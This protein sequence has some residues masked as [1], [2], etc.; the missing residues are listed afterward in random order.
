[1]PDWVLRDVCDCVSWLQ[2]VG[3]IPPELSIMPNIT[4]LRF[5]NNLMTGTIPQSFR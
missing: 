1:M 3:T 4:S 5:E 2:L